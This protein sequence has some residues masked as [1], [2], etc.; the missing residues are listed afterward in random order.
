MQTRGHRG[1]VRRVSDRAELRGLRRCRAE[2]NAPDARRPLG[3]YLSPLSSSSQLSHSGQTHSLTCRVEVCPVPGMVS[4]TF[5]TVSRMDSP[6]SGH[7]LISATSF[8]LPAS[9]FQHVVVNLTGSWRL[10]AGN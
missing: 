7:S 3:P 5:R 2:G 6:Q 8:Q 10:E 4:V 1:S 9:S